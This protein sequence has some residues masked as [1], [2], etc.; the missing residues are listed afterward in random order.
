MTEEVRKIYIG[1]ASRMLKVCPA[2]LRLWETSGQLL[3]DGKSKG[4]RR[5]YYEKTIT[6]FLKN[7]PDYRYMRG[8]KRR[9]N[10][11]VE[12]VRE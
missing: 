12:K 6:D 8:R 5:Y 2:T 3:P 4:D 10:G 7:T 11:K 9:N 1:E